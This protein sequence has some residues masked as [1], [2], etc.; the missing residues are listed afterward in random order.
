MKLPMVEAVDGGVKVTVW[1]KETTR[2]DVKDVTKELT[3]R[4]AL[5]YNMTKEN[6]IKDVVITAATLSERFS[7]DELTILNT[8][9]ST[10]CIWLRRAR[11]CSVLRR[12]RQRRV[13]T[14]R[15]VEDEVRNRGTHDHPTHPRATTV[16]DYNVPTQVVNIRQY[17]SI[18][19]NSRQ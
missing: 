5:N 2:D 17:S 14:E 7:V 10:L 4:Q 19:V 3:E 16:R 15:T 6:V 12:Q 1:R 8:Q 18:F 11:I 9:P 13:I